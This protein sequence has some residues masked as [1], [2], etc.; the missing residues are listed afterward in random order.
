MS[1]TL[2]PAATHYH[3]SPLKPEGPLIAASDIVERID[4]YEIADEPAKCPVTSNP[5]CRFGLTFSLTGEKKPLLDLAGS[6]PLSRAPTL[7]KRLSRSS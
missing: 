6:Y 2:L 4:F 7:S 5:E 3:P 1:L